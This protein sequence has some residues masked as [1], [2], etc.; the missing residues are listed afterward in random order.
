[1]LGIGF[2]ADGRNEVLTA[3]REN[4]RAGAS[5]IKV[6]AG[7]GA[8]SAL[9]PT[10][11]IPVGTIRSGAPGTS[12]ME[13]TPTCRLGP[14]CGDGAGVLIT[15]GTGFSGVMAAIRVRP[16]LLPDQVV[17][18]FDH[19]GRFARGSALSCGQTRRTH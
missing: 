13:Q 8:A 5:Q 11:V 18:L 10:V 7:G 19:S 17:T 16:R 9:L 3:T 15:I 6:M 1:M 4:L 12:L 2:I 14:R